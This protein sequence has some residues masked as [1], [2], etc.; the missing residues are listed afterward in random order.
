MTKQSTG[1]GLDLRSRRFT[2]YL[3]GMSATA[4]E[5]V[6]ASTHPSVRARALTQM[7]AGPFSLA[8]LRAMVVTALLEVA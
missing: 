8:R 6:D 5:L 3:R 2:P 4:I 1:R 7:P